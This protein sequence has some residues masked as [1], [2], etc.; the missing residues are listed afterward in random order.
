A[1]VT[2]PPPPSA[3]HDNDVWWNDLG[4]DSRDTLYRTP[5]GPVTTGTAVT[6][7]LRAASGDLTDAKVRLYN[8]RPNTEQFLNMTLVADDG[9]YEWW[10]AQV[11]A[12]TEPTVY[13]YRFIAIDGTA[14]AYYEDDAAR[15]QGWGQ[16]FG[17]S[18]DNSWQITVYDPAF[19]TPD[20]VKNGIMYQIFGDR[21]RDGDPGN[22]TPAGTFFYNESPTIVRSNDADGNWNT[23]ICD[24]RDATSD[25]PGIYSQNFYGG[26]LQGVLDELDYLQNLG[27]TVIYFNPI[28][29]S[30]S[31]HKY[32]TTDYSLI[33][34][35]FGDEALFQTLVDE[36]H[37]RGMKVVL[38]GV[39][40]HTSSDSIYFDRYGRYPDVG[41]CESETS[42]SGIGITSPT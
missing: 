35:N 2:P 9:T 18:P 20:W 8:D 33:D 4:H 17:D 15:D 21:F 12:S 26:D 5:G 28:F 14:T 40:N 19:Q 29:E 23:V 37:A 3:G 36:A 24:P 1:V 11:P 7:R 10:E 39:F 13:W 22:N 31:N 16:T 6:L 42:P 41:A 30:P 25:C 38:D 32:D 34:D 27:V